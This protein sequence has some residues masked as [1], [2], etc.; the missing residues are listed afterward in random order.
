MSR[1]PP[2]IVSIS[3]TSSGGIEVRW[4]VDDFF[5]DTEAPEA[6]IIE[7]NGV[8]IKKLDG[9]DTSFEI[10]AAAIAP[11]AQSITIGVIFWWSGEPPEEQQSAASVLVGTGA[12]AGVRPAATPILTILEVRPRT[13]AGPN[14]ITIGWKSD[15]YNDGNILWGPAASP[16]AFKHSITPKGENYSGS[17]TTDRPLLPVTLYRFKVEVRNTLHSP[18]WVHTLLSVLSAEN[19][20]SLRQFLIASGRPVTTPVAAVVGPDRSVHHLLVG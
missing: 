19:S 10:P 17:F 5:A 20:L 16:E 2:D 14:R 12:S 1:R 7:L 15:N 13:L 9:D 3:P 4:K 8:A 11:S 18:T 6:V